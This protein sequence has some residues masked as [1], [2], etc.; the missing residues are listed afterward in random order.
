MSGV[1]LANVVA[2]VG[3]ALS[4]ARSLAVALCRGNRLTRA[5]AEMNLWLALRRD[6][7]TAFG[8]VGSVFLV[9]CMRQ[10]NSFQAGERLARGH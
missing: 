10:G 3:V 8:L 7:G 6:S 1:E 4:V 2:V 9:K 5:L